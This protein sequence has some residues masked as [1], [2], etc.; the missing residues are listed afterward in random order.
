MLFMLICAII[1]LSKFFALIIFRS[2]IY[3]FSDT[4]VKSID[5]SH[6]ELGIQVE[7]I[8]L[9]TSGSTC[10]VAG[11][12]ATDVKSIGGLHATIGVKMELL[13]LLTPDSKCGVAVVG[14][15][16]VNSLDG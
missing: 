13:K 10:G 16:T 6:S 4:P 1:I 3:D 15:T 5:V 12:A 7:L 11:V 14:A 9:L 8:K 2:S